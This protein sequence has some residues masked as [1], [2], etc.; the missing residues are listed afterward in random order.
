[1]INV[2]DI[3]KIE[4]KRRDLRKEIYTKIFEQFSRKIKQCVELNQKYATLTVPSFLLGYPT[5]DRELA[6]SYLERQLGRAGFTVVREDFVF[7]VSWVKKARE[8]E[9]ERDRE[10]DPEPP[11]DAGFPSLVNL[12]KAANKYRRG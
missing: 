1:M 11:E 6:A 4:Q 10:P 5:F 9:R 12:R 3:A 8:R 7:V 2:R